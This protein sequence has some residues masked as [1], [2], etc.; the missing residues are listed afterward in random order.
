MEHVDGVA[1]F[2]WQQGRG[3]R[4]L[5]PLRR[6][7]LRGAQPTDDLIA[8][9]A[10]RCGHSEERVRWALTES[11]GWDSGGFVKAVRTLYDLHKLN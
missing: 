1:R 9:L 5:T 10:Q 7:V 4:L 6:L 11:P 2:Y 3:N 8:D